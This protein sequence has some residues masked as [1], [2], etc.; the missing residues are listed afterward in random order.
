LGLTTDAT[1]ARYGTQIYCSCSQKSTFVS[2]VGS[3][4]DWD[5]SQREAGTMPRFVDRDV[6]RT[7]DQKTFKG[8]EDW[9]R[10]QLTHAGLL[11]VLTSA[12]E[13]L[14][15]VIAQQI[16]IPPVRRVAAAIETG[17]VRVSWARIPLARVLSYRVDRVEGDRTTTNYSEADSFLDRDVSE[18]RSYS[19]SVSAILANR[20]GPIPIAVPAQQRLSFLAQIAPNRSR[21]WT[22]PT[23]T[24]PPVPDTFY[25][26]APS[27]PVTIRVVLR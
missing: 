3:A 21:A 10:I 18:G 8:A 9:S 7:C 11:P 22:D 20:G 13:E 27:P 5:C 24:T 6:D 25:Q 15:F 12:V 16:L 4:I 19:Y 2:T 14:T 23:P 26:T 1:Q 17:G